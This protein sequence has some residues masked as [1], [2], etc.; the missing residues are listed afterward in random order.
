MTDEILAAIQRGKE[1][2]LEW[3]RLNAEAEAKCD[4]L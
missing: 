4:T 3:N 1:I 2:I